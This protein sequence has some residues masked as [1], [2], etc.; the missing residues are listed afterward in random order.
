MIS[1]AWRQ[2]LKRFL[3]RLLL[4]AEGCIARWP[5]A[6]FRFWPMEQKKI[7]GV[8]L[9]SVCLEG[10]N[11]I[12][13][14]NLIKTLLSLAFQRIGP[15]EV[16]LLSECSA[17][18]LKKLTVGFKSLD[19]RIFN[20]EDLSEQVNG[21]DFLLAHTLGEFVIFMPIGAIVSSQ[22]TALLAERVHTVANNMA[23]ELDEIILKP[24]GFIDDVWLSRR[25][26]GPYELKSSICC[27]GRLLR[28]GQQSGASFHN[29]QQ[30]VGLQGCWIQLPGRDW[31][32]PDQIKPLPVAVSNLDQ[33]LTVVIPTIRSCDPEGNPLVLGLLRLLAEQV[34]VSI[35]VVVVD[36]GSDPSI[37]YANLISGAIKSLKVVPFAADGAEFNFSAKVNAGIA[38]V[39]TEIVVL[40]NDDLQPLTTSSIAALLGPLSKP[41]VGIVGA[42][43][44]FPDGSLQH[45][46]VIT[47]LA[48]P[49]FHPRHGIKLNGQRLQLWLNSLRE[50]SAVTGAV[51]AFRCSKLAM[52]KGFDES[53]AVEFNDTDFCLRARDNGFLIIYQGASLFRHLEKASRSQNGYLSSINVERKLFFKRW[54]KRLGSDPMLDDPYMHPWLHVGDVHQLL[55]NW[56]NSAF[57]EIY[58]RRVK[59]KAK[60]LFLELGF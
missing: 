5:I 39:T 50:V 33:Q 48:R 43:L 14:L 32:L 10:N 8:P 53:L 3:R 11:I 60:K 27:A 19:I 9:L 51:M 38:A 6:A 55:P 36:A 21:P 37:F 59:L 41:E 46:G 30:I 22:L 7:A 15:V 1:S 42:Q 54:H 56:H 29:P 58:C 45:G 2:P 49:P 24:N 26:W 17:N 34:E 28:K 40:L 13:N 25:R 31:Q 47:G 4:L 44:L 23:L 16:L 20:S 12:F 52:L 35:D 57:I 18:D